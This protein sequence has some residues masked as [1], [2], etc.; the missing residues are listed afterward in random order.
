MSIEIAPKRLHKWA[1]VLLAFFHFSV[2]P[3]PPVKVLEQMDA[4]SKIHAMVLVCFESAEYK[5]L[6]SEDALKFHRIN[7]LADGVIEL[8]EKKYSDPDAYMA[9][10]YASS[11][12]KSDSNFRRRLVQIYS[13]PCPP[14]FLIDAEREIQ[15]IH[16]LVRNA[17]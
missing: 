14:Q 7:Q 15:I 5:R 17:K 6:P 11:G 1:I 4:L 8:V 3:K 16:Q 13:R 12:Y 10:M 2:W 9:F